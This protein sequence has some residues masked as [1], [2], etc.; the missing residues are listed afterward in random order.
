MASRSKKTRVRNR[1]RQ[2]V[3][4]SAGK[5]FADLGLPDADEPQT[6]VHLAFGVNRAIARLRIS[7]AEAARMLSLKRPQVAAL[8]VYR[9]NGFS[10]HALMRFLTILSRRSSGLGTS[11][12]REVSRR[13]AALGGTAP[14]L[15][16]VPRR[17]SRPRS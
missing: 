13:L 12:V 14:S 6:K 1:E 5:V 4:S 10:V 16:P 2:R 3:V 11:R 9:L 15:R 17:R 7:P 8:K